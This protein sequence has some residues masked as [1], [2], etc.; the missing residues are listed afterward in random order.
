M[1]ESNPLVCMVRLLM[2]EGIHQEVGQLL[3]TLYFL[4]I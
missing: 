1:A 2:T 4:Y 3:H